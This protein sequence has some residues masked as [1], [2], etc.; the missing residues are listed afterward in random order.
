[1]G[2]TGLPYECDGDSSE[3]KW[4]VGASGG[5]FQTTIEFEGDTRVDLEQASVSAILGYQVSTRVGLVAS[6]GA[7]LAGEVDVSSSEDMG[8]GVLGSLTATYLPFYE[9][10]TRPFILGSFTLGHSRTSAVSDDGR[11]HDWTA[12]D[13]RL[14][15]MVGKTF[16]ERY[17]PFVVAR[18]FAGPVSWT[19]GGEDVYGGDVYHYTVGVGASYRIPGTLDLFAE[20]LALGERSASFG[21]SLPL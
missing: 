16:A 1:M 6:L 7:I 10:E 14:G 18:A 2:P 5:A 13:G 11:R 3:S 12:V 20:V 4:R 17:V 19:L 15:L 9:T 8:K 21:M